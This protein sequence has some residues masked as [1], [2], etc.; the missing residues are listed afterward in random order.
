MTGL[1]FPAG[2][3]VVIGVILIVDY[4]S[5]RRQQA[6]LARFRAEQRQERA[7]ARALRPRTGDVFGAPIDAPI[8]PLDMAR[9]RHANGDDAA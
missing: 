4:R 7:A 5:Y 2:C 3:V 1:L 6:E 9:A 8:Y